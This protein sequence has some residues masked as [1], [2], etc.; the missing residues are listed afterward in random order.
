MRKS[1]PIG[2]RVEG[3]PPA[4]SLRTRLE[5]L[6]AP[7]RAMSADE[8]RREHELP[9]AAELLKTTLSLCAECLAH[10]PAAVYAAQGRVFMSKRCATHGL[11]RALLESDERFYRL[12]NKDRW[13]RAYVTDRT[14][15]VPEFDGACCGPGD[16]CGS[17]GPS[18]TPWTYDSTDQRS[19]KTCTVLI[20]ITD[21][22]NLACHVCYADSKGDRILSLEGFRSHVSALLDQKGALDSVQL[23][24]GEPTIHPDFWAMLAW[25]HAEPRVAKIYVATNGIA[26]EKPGVAQKLVP[27]RDKTLVL[28]QFDGLEAK[29]NKALRQANP[30]KVRMRLLARLDRLNVPM[31]LTMTLAR[32]VSER[33]IAWVVRQ[34]VRHRNVR[35]V[36]M[37]PAF[38]SGRF[39]IEHDPLDRI[40]LSDVVKGVTAGLATRDGDFLPI[41]CSHPNC[42]WVTLFARRFG[43]FA[44]IARHV[45]LNA[46]MNEVAYKTVLDR[47]S[48][49]DIVGTRREGF[50]TRLLAR[51][52]RKLIR[53]RDVFGIVVKPFMDRY[54]YDQ[55]RV[56]ACCHHVL[57]T[58]GRLE[59]FCEYN[60]RHRA[61]D[62]W[63]SLP[64]L[65]RKVEL[66]EIARGEEA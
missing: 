39:S 35:L 66:A 34:G 28:L 45:D 5:V 22:C 16:S 56:S 40:T 41:P 62:S 24:G 33:E 13:G 55:D 29:T 31:Q 26:L 36:A 64:R 30:E 18:P 7:L 21:A 10:V 8:V 3:R 49:Q 19:N 48:M 2:V 27:F 9:A 57:D 32:G 43:L 37:L 50:F 4:D 53:P 58:Q 23:I 17:T 60:A 61:A 14:E 47:R 6:A 1:I 59:S 20:E 38:F 65:P 12:S 15:H 42:G 46:V 51:L 52:A 44:N 11:A 54:N 63:Q 25:L